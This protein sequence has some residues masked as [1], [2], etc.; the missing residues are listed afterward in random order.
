MTKAEMMRCLEPFDD[1]IEIVVF[2]I[3]DNQERMILGFSYT[4]SEVDTPAYISLSIPQ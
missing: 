1:E 3:R 2:S 4:Q